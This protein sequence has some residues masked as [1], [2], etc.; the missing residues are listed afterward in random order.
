MVKKLLIKVG[1]FIEKFD[2]LLKRV[3]LVFKVIEILR[4]YILCI[5]WDYWFIGIIL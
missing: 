5:I 3:F 2:W 4:E 1:N